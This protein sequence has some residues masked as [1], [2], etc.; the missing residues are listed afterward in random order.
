[1]NR[2]K[3]RRLISV[4]FASGLCGL[5]TQTIASGFQ[6]WEQDGASGGSYHAGYAAEVNDATAAWY[7]PAGIPRIQNQQAVFS[8]EAIQTDFDYKGNVGVTES[9]PSMSGMQPVTVTFDSVKANGGTFNTIPSLNYV[10][11]INEYIGFGFSVVVPF[12]LKTDYGK[13][14]PL[15][16]AAT[17][18]SIKVIDISPS[19]GFRFTDK[20]SFGAGFDVQRAYAKF[21]NIAGLIN[22]ANQSEIIADTTSLNRADDTGYGYHLGFLYEFTPCTRVGL[23]YHSQVAH[24]LSGSS[25]FE[26]EIA[27]L[28]ND[29]QPI[30]SHHATANITLPPYTALSIFNKIS[31]TWAVMG[32]VTYTQWST[33]KTLTLKQAAGAVPSDTLIVEP[34]TNIEVNIPQNYRDTWNLSVGANYYPT[35]SIIVRGGLGYDKTPVR[36]AYRN[37]QLPDGDRYAASIGSHYQVTKTVGLDAAWIHIFARKVDIHPP[38]QVIG[39]EAVSTHGHVKGNANVV[40]GQ[41]TWDML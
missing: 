19:L 22:P 20:A 18:S 31:P 40:S 37:V 28:L 2:F 12:G 41:V 17:L 27:D 25:K 34:S 35:D 11:P 30:I 21:N 38:V 9:L 1:M 16:Y 10:A 32:T 33:F 13:D 29:D 3:T 6:L 23:S 4:L 24:H 39:A 7:N 36:N 15:R 14:T 26:G 8:V 5:S